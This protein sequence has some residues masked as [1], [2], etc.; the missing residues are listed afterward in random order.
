M[1]KNV[2][3]VFQLVTRTSSAAL[4][5]VGKLVLL[6]PTL[7]SAQ[8]YYRIETYNL[9]Q[10]VNFEAS[11]LAVMP[12]GKLAVGLRKGEVW[13]EGEK[14]FKLFA[15]GLHEILGLAFHEGALYATQRA[16]VTKIRDTDGDG[17]ADE[18]LTAAAGWGVS[19]A[20]HEYAYG[21]VFDAAGNLY[22]SLNCSMGKPMI[23]G[24]T[25]WR[26]WVV[27][28][29]P[30]GQMEPWCAGFRSPCGIG[31]NF[32][33]DVFV[34]DQQG[35]W[36]PTTP[37]FHARKGAYFSHADSIPDA[38]RPDSPVKINAKQ[39]DGI[40]VAEAMK[41]VPGYCPPAVWLPYVKMG[42][43]G[44][45][46]VCDRSGGK[47]GP[48]E[49]QLFMGEFVLSG[50]N[51]VFLEKVGGEYQ[52]ACF[53]FIDGL[54]CAALALTTLP[55]GSL[56]V[57]ESNRGWNSK[58]MCKSSNSPKPVSAS[59]S[60]CLS[61]KSANSPVR[62]TPTPSKANT[63]AKNSMRSLCKS[64]P[65]N[66][67]MTVSLSMSP[68]PIFAKVMCMNLSFRSSKPRTARRCGT[69]WPTTH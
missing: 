69:A 11:G 45:G 39:P 31:T 68:S 26:G 29:S 2:E 49:K 41:K 56:V 33:G 38:M 66:S 19:G 52:G 12:N 5:R 64:P 1:V 35:N 37:I 23:K 62:V 4:K 22:T 10:G 3:R 61:R 34:S 36:M 59:P 55:D 63:A 14:G 6:L 65:L 57:G 30:S 21:P 48:F 54:Q 47:F 8:D 24:D 13:V 16:E 7:L 58:A 67:A 28:T 53:P 15:S 51:R 44:T 42:Q 60:L 43:S 18:Y 32:E 20:Y 50:V 25:L 17:T 9:P 27:R 40:T 46:I